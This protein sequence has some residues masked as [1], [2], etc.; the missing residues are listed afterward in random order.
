MRFGLDDSVIEK[1]TEVFEAHPKVDKAYIFGSRAKGN[2]RAD[3]D[4]DIAIKGYG[5]T[6]DDIL[7]MSVAFEDKG[8][9]HKIDLLDYNEIKEPAL[10]EH[11]DRVGVEF[12]SRWKEYKFSELLLDE[13]ISY[14][15]VQPGT[16]TEIN[17]V[18]IIRGNNLKNGKII[19]DEIMKVSATIEE[20]FLRTRLIGGELLITVVGSVGECAIVPAALK[21]WNVARAISVA[22]IKQ[23]FDTEY[24]K[25]AFKTDDL[26]FQ[27]YGNTNDT[28][29]PTL[30]LSSL[31]GLILTLPSF[32]EQNKITSILLS[33]DNKIDL[34]HRQ[35][36]TLEQ[37]AETLFRQWFVE[38]AEEDWEEKRLIDVIKLIGGGTPKTENPEYWDGNI[39][40]I[41]ARDITPNHKGFIS[42]TEKSIT[43]SGLKNSSAKIIEKYSTIISARGTVGKYCLLSEP[44][45]F[46]QSNYGIQPKLGGL[47]FFTYLLIAHSVEELQAA[48][49]GSVFDT[50]TT[51]TFTEHKI[52]IPPET[53]LFQFEKKIESYFKKI[54]SN[55]TQIQSLTK[56]RDTLLPKLM[57]GEVRVKMPG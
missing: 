23:G 16:H 30:N 42:N 2:F 53:D 3:S 57:S 47:F 6:L 52:K 50:I 54:E 43:E 26:A 38:E 7:K 33:L 41:S 19:T 24:I 46:S 25:Y 1:L 14:G 34:L 39:K 36:K 13:S 56:M 9:T 51:N 10:I 17:S 15:I 27:M 11:I 40:W 22:R 21:G 31:K 20:K 28:V 49:Y 8:I 35:N 4:I 32:K 37:L 55:Q 45:A 29:Q 18:P 48:A 12:Y 44:M 5:L